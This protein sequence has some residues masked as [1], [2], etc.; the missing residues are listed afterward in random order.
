MPVLQ[1]TDLDVAGKKVYVR[2]DFNVPLADD[3]TITDDTR[4]RAA[5]PTVQWLREHGAAVILA[6]HLGR[7]KG[8]AVAALR[9][10]RSQAKSGATCRGRSV[11]ARKCAL[12]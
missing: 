5:V 12:P 2:V 4:L 8:K 10:R 9:G 6:A 1:V 3:G 7:P 11:A